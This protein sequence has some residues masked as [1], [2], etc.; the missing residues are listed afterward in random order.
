MNIKNRIGIFI[1]LSITPIWVAAQDYSS[2]I[3]AET[4]M[5]IHRNL[6]SPDYNKAPESGTHFG[7]GFGKK[8]N[9]NFKMEFSTYHNL[10][11]YEAI[12][13]DSLHH[14]DFSTHAGFINLI[15]G[16][17]NNAKLNPFFL[18]GLGMSYNKA[19]SLKIL[20]KN[21]AV[22]PSDSNFSAA[23][24]IGA[25]TKYKLSYNMDLVF[26]YKYINL[27]AA[28]TDA[29]A[30]TDNKSFAYPPLKAKLNHHAITIGAHYN[31]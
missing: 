4:G 9:D 5:T 29:R 31:F 27:G 14:Q 25:G 7:V 20:G 18:F 6:R 30:V 21:P 15:L 12:H 19:S 26:T 23:Y 28:K 3:K 22:V 16:A 11:R 17:E 10:A 13:K 8:L 2:Y 24:Q 1:I